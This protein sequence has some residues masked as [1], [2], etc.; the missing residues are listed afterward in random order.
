MKLIFKI[1]LPVFKI[2]G[3]NSSSPEIGTDCALKLFCEV[4]ISGPRR[5]KDL[6]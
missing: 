2:A 1:S 4:R 5:N 3:Q 6:M